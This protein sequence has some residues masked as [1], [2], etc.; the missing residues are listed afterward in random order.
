VGSG[1]LVVIHILSTEGKAS[2]CV[3]IIQ[4]FFRH[5]KE[6]FCFFSLFVFPG[7][8]LYIGGHCLNAHFFEQRIVNSNPLFA[9]PGRPL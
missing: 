2:S 3:I 9:L 6:N 7:P 8:F 1:V 5:R 4:S